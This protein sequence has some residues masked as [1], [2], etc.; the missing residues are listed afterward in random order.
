[1]LLAAFFMFRE[2]T[3][4]ITGEAEWLAEAVDEEAMH[5]AAVLPG[6]AP[7]GRMPLGLIVVEGLAVGVLT[8]LVGVGGGFLIVP[9]LVLLGKIP[10]KQA[11]GTSLL[12]IAMKSAAGFV[13][14]LGQVEVPWGFM[15]LFTAV[16]VVGILGGTYLVQ[17]VSQAAL[18]RAFA[19]FLVLM[20]GF[21]LYQNRA[22]LIPHGTAEART[23]PGAAGHALPAATNPALAGVAIDHL[24]R[25]PG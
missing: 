15:T 23:S 11:V 6:G 19:V 7:V 2:K 21:I 20:G 24:D 10:M 4:V 14:Y 17:Y 12:V 13:G 9:A 5:D 22:V 18:K 3:P 25:D 16:A 8:G 1:M